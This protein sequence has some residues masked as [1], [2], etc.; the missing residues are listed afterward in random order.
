MAYLDDILIYTKGTR[1]EHERETKEVLQ[2]LKKQ[3]I[4]LN[5]EKSEYTKEK[6]TFLGTII[7]REGLAMEPEKTKAVREW[8]TPKTVKEVQAF[9]GFANYYRRFIKNYSSQAGP[10]TQLTKKDQAFEWGPHQEKAFEGMKAL[11]TDESTLESHNPEKK[12]TV[13]ILRSK[14]ILQEHDAEQKKT[15]ETDASQWA[16]AACLSQSSDGKRGKPVAFHSR[17]LTPAEQNYDIHDKELLA[18]VDAFKHWR[19]YLQGARHEISV[20][21][22]HKNLTSFTTTK[23]LNK[24]QVC[25]TEELSSYNFKISYRKGSEN[26]AADTLS[27]RPDYMEKTMSKELQILKKDEEGNLRPNKGIAIAQRITIDWG[28]DE[29][30]KAYAKDTGA[31]QLRSQKRTDD[32]AQE[33]E[34]ILYWKGRIYLPTSLRE[35]WVRKT[36]EH[37]SAGHPG[38][39]KTTELVARDYYFPGIIRTVKKVIKECD[40]CNRTKYNRHAPYGKLQTI[41]PF[42]RPWQEIAFDLITKLQLS[43]EPMTDMEYDSIWTVTDLLTKYTY[44]IPFKEGSTAEQLAYMFQRTIVATHGMPDTVISDRGMTYTSKFWQSLMAQLG[45][46]HKCSTAFHPQTDGQTE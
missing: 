12:L 30:Q 44:F 27:R 22:D 26:Q 46:K 5:K 3:D 9:L 45:I 18:I 1:E 37:P 25:W 17:K 34:V 20:I 33:R 8:P 24:Q 28:K 19:H 14:G 38:I 41:K 42:E 6:V 31:K 16:I 7:S 23:T 29:I 35:G 11:F 21:T 36:H 4:H 43:K 32:Q 39:G 13:E 10:L 40:K 2:L 15:M